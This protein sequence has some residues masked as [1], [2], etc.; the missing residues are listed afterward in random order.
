MP[1]RTKV[2][3]RNSCPSALRLAVPLVS[4][5]IPI[6]GCQNAAPT[7]VDR[8]ESIGLGDFTVR[9][10]R[11]E[12]LSV[13]VLGQLAQVLQAP[14]S[15][16]FLSVVLRVDRESSEPESGSARPMAEL[17][18]DLMMGLTLED[19][20]GS[21][22]QRPITVPSASFRMMRSAGSVSGMTPQD[23]AI[24]SRAQTSVRLPGDWVAVFSVPGDAR[25]FQLLIRNR[26]R[27]G[28]QPRR[29]A[30]D[31]GR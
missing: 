16:S 8:G 18:S 15:S 17:V 24:M 19:G 31:L 5:L 30:V 27:Q 2:P 29:V 20:Q 13:D 21:R 23:L 3:V 6:G 25:D 28:D 9:V 22:Y 4:M 12:M 1:S 14:P 7:V 26:N 10:S 11:V